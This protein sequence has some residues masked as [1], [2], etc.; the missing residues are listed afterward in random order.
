MAP[1]VGTTVTR[2]VKIEL[3]FASKFSSTACICVQPLIRAMD[4][5]TSSVHGLSLELVSQA[6]L[7]PLPQQILQTMWG[8]N[9][10]DW[11]MQ[12]PVLIL[13]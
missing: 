7:I 1:R 9:N 5:T 13:L 2:V 12:I 8:V 4:E 10:S 3:R 6:Q 11:K